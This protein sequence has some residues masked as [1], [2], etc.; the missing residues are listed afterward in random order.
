MVFSFPTVANDC[1][2][3]KPDGVMVMNGGPESANPPD[4]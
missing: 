1:L 3:N 4:T 2:T